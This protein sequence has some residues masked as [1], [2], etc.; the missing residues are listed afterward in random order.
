MSRLSYL[1]FI[2]W[3]HSVSF[4]STPTH[5]YLHACLKLASALCLDESYKQ[6][7]FYTCSSFRTPLFLLSNLHL[8]SFPLVSL[9]FSLSRILNAI[10]HKT[11]VHTQLLAFCFANVISFCDLLVIELCSYLLK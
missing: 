10:L 5:Q 11:L 8:F 1:F 7:S 6:S 3:K 9:S 4:K 2:T